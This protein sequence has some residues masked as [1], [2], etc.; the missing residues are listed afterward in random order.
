MN[1][2]QNCDF[3]LYT[4]LIENK[5]LEHYCKNCSWKDTQFFD[6]KMKNNKSICVYEKKYTN[7]YIAMKAIK[8]PYTIYDPTLPRVSNIE[9]INKLC[10]TNKQDN[11]KQI[12]IVK[13][14]QFLKGDY[15]KLEAE[16]FKKAKSKFDI[17][18]VNEQSAFIEFKDINDLK[19]VTSL[20]IEGKDLEVEPFKDIEREIIFIK[21]DNINLKY[22]Y[23]CSTCCTSWKSQ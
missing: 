1:F 4:R 12:L 15:S 2:C 18:K 8:N 6:D 3:M 19:N 16:V 14:I 21:Y 11:K 17:F 20:T 7:E 22:L 5:Q 13:N 10:L 23:L 9:C